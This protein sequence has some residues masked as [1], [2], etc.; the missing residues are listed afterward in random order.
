MSQNECGKLESER[1]A[2]ADERGP[3]QAQAEERLRAL[4]VTVMGALW[5]ASSFS[6]AVSDAQL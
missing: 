1:A 5:E 6:L 2:L 3:M 4:Q